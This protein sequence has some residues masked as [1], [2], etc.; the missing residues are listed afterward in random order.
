LKK[1]LHILQHVNLLMI[2]LTM[3]FNLHQSFRREWR[4]LLK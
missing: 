4:H 1:L 3:I 2:L